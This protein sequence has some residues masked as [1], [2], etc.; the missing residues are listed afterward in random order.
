MDVTR[1]LADP[2]TKELLPFLDPALPSA[3][4]IALLGIAQGYSVQQLHHLPGLKNPTYLRAALDA[5][6]ARG[7]VVR[8]STGLI[9]SSGAAPDPVHV[10]RLLGQK[11]FT[12]A[13][14]LLADPAGGLYA[15]GLSGMAVALGPVLGAALEEEVR[16]V[17]A[18]ASADAEFWR[19]NRLSRLHY[20]ER[21][22]PRDRSRRTPD[23]PRPLPP[24]PDFLDR[25]VH[26]LTYGLPPAVRDER[27]RVI[28]GLYRAVVGLGSTVFPH[29]WAILTGLERHRLGPDALWAAWRGRMESY[30]LRRRKILGPALRYRE[31]EPYVLRVRYP[32]PEC[33]YG[34]WVDH[35]LAL[36]RRF[37]RR[38][39]PALG[40]LTKDLWLRTHEEITLQ[41]RQEYPGVEPGMV[42]RRLYEERITLVA[43]RLSGLSHGVLDDLA[44]GRRSAAVKGVRGRY[45]R[46]A[47]ARLER[48]AIRR[49]VRSLVAAQANGGRRS[50]DRLRAVLHTVDLTDTSPENWAVHLLDTIARR[51]PGEQLSDKELTILLKQAKSKG[52]GGMRF[53][54]RTVAEQVVEELHD[55]FEA[56]PVVVGPGERFPL[57]KVQSHV[58]RCAEVSRLA[59]SNDDQ[60]DAH[61]ALLNYLLNC[62]CIDVVVSLG[63]SQRS[64]I[65]D[66]CR[67]VGR[68]FMAERVFQLVQPARMAA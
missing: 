12:A 67:L 5:L 44:R 39:S 51:Q 61:E 27:E 58:R 41:L 52:R 33:G 7:R 56:D 65:A 54:H 63:T 36:W 35:E 48:L 68:P 11:K 2:R 18:V 24:P 14:E 16:R 17:D 9:A 40:P 42:S 13:I 43:D 21:N 64:T 19:R 55:L 1:F 10:A 28:R 3:Q 62:V 38:Y 30:L 31:E 22:V 47:G 37:L 50:S 4:R 45:E 66:A 57:E 15:R 6:V 20:A 26:Q 32:V 60:R 46:E 34:P 25:T 49:A 23:G 8:H 59:V 29:W 53:R